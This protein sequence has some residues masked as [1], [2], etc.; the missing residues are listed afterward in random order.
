[1]SRKKECELGVYNFQDIVYDVWC[2]TLLVLEQ[3]KK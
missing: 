3:N 1:M 2:K